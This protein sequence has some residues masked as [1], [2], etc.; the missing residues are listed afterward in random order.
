MNLNKKYFKYQIVQGLAS[1]RND[2]KT[3]KNNPTLSS[4]W[5]PLP[6][7]PSDLI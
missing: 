2:L 6:I 5:K 3:H 7:M 4:L 1:D